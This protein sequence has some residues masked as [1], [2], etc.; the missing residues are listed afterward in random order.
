MHQILK[1]EGSESEQPC[2]LLQDGYQMGPG[3]A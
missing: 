3:A 2:S 1:G